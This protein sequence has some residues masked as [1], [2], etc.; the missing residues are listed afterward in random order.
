MGF[1]LAR[2]DI[3][4]LA[5]SREDEL[6]IYQLSRALAAEATILIT[7]HAYTAI[8]LARKALL[9]AE[10][11]PFDMLVVDEADQWASA[12]SSVLLV[13]TSITDLHRSI[14]NLLEASRHLKNSTELIEQAARTLRCVEAL[15][16]LA[17]KT[18]DCSKTLS[19]GDPAIGH[20]SSVACNVYNLIYIASR[21]RS[22][23]AAAADALRDKFDDLKRIQ[24]AV[25]GNETE[26]WTLRW[27]TSRVHGLP[28]IGVAGRAPGRIL[29]ALVERRPTARP[30][31]RPDLRDS[32]HAGFPG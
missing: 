12:A 20:L 32:Q 14:D 22:H 7:T 13:S 1:S 10:E 21:R 24:R 17:P 18:P 27:T 8:S 26:F 19:A 15:A 4:L 30:D 28:S 2:E 29:E 31:Y 16:E 9:D 5:S 25:V 6:A 11:N 23:T 3:C